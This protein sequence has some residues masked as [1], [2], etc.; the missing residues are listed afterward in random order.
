[1]NL[2]ARQ[3]KCLLEMLSFDPK[4]YYWMLQ[5][6]ASLEVMG[7]TKRDHSC[8]GPAYTLTDAG[9]EMVKSLRA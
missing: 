8:V 5:T 1:M 9:R 3:K 2:T 7:L 4:P 6:C